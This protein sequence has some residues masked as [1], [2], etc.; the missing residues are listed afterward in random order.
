MLIFELVRRLQQVQLAPASHLI[1]SIINFRVLC[2]CIGDAQ[3][4]EVARYF[5]NW[6]WT[7]ILYPSYPTRSA[8]ELALVGSAYRYRVAM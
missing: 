5:W 3:G 2:S 1:S 6:N 8:P 4:L 7:G